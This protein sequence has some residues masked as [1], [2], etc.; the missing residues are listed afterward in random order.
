MKSAEDFLREFMKEIIHNPLDRPNIL[1]DY[2][3]KLE[4]RDR[5]IQGGA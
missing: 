3:A 2:T 5:Q 4:E 1:A